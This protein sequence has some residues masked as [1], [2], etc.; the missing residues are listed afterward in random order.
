MVSRRR[1]KEEEEEEAGAGYQ[2][3]SRPVLGVAKRASGQRGE[4]QEEGMEAE[5][6]RLLRVRDDNDIAGDCE[7]GAMRGQEEQ[8]P[9]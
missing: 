5:E 8:G 6:E 1:E 9:A 4:K 3:L 7:S 2:W